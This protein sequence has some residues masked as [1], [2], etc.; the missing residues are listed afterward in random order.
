MSSPAKSMSMLFSVLSKLIFTTAS[1]FIAAKTS[2]KNDLTLS[3]TEFLTLALITAGLDLSPRKP[4]E[5]SSTTSYSNLSLV[6]E[7]LW[8]ASVMASSTVLAENSL[9]SIIMSPYLL[10]LSLYC[11]TMLALEASE[12]ALEAFLLL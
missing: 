2:F 9:K 8:H 4:V 6:T 11:L 5:P 3:S 1:I 12:P 7:R 10:F